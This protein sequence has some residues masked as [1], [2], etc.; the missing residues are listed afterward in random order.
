MAK[1][2]PS[3][4]QQTSPGRQTKAE[5]REQARR[6]RQ[7][8]IRKQ[9]IRRKRRRLATVVGAVV[10]AAA[11]AGGVVLAVTGSGGKSGPTPF[12]PRTLP[13]E[14]TQTEAPWPAN[15]P[16]IQALTRA[17]TIHL[18][19]AGNVF[20]HHDLLQLYINGQTDTVPAGTGLRPQGTS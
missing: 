10:I 13:G 5:R 4:T 17:R 14:L 9:A 19:T 8:L 1:R 12:D 11:V 16:G 18:P 20:H 3:R 15:A 2:P 6:E 7:E